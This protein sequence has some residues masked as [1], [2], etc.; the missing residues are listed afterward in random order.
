MLEHWSVGRARRAVE[1]L[2]ELSP[3]KA[4]YICPHDGDILEKPIAEVPVGV[5]VLV[6]PGDRIPLDGRITKGITTVNQSPITGESIR[7]E[8]K[9]GDEVFAGT[10][11]EDGAIEFQATKL[12]GDTILSGI[13][14]LVKESQGKRAASQR[15]VETF[16]AYYTPLMMALSLAIMVLPPFIVGAS[17]HTWFYRGLVILVIACPCALVIS[18]PVSIMAALTAAARNGVLVKGGLYLEAVGR[19][20][21]VAFDKTGTLTNGRPDVQQVVPLNGHSHRDLLERAAALESNSQHPLATAILRKAQ[22]EGVEAAR[23]EN[24]QAVK[25]KGAIGSVHGKSF[26]IGSRRFMEEKGM[27]TKEIRDKAE[28]FEDAGHSVV[29]VGNESHVCGL[30]TISDTPR[31]EAYQCIRDLRRQ[32]IGKIVMLTGDNFGTASAIAEYTGVDEFRAALLPEEKVK[33]IEALIAKFGATAMI[34][35]G[36][37][38][39]PAM[40]GA[41]LGIAMG[42]IG[43]D[44]AIETADIVF[45]SDDLAKLPWLIGHSRRTLATVKTNICIALGLKILFIGLSLLGM[46]SLGMAIAAD[47]GASLLVVFNGLRLLRR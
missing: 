11:N 37:N 3:A 38:D 41:S 39:A 45:M 14:R 7:V 30:I 19:L 23:A 47:M 6:R 33:A 4:R 1:S 26:W 9:I 42:A 25:G 43:T 15:F 18:T 36:V 22:A 44:T 31:K 17:W 12:A 46:A 16:A 40:A 5:T 21:V 27:G 8:K 13:I 2:L 20:M 34:G 35:D 28:S 10:I 32:G 24:Y 29:V